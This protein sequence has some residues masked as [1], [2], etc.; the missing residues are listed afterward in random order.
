MGQLSRELNVVRKALLA[1]PPAERTPLAGPASFRLAD[2]YV[3]FMAAAA[4]LGVWRAAADDFLADP[5]WLATALHRTA[6]RLSLRPAPPPAEHTARL[7][8]ELLR[9]HDENRSFDL[10]DLCLNG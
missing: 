5:A 8:A 1:L 6:T 9:R 2:R 7:H 3:H 4:A 10:Y